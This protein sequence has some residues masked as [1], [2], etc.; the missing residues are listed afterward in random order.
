MLGLIGV[1]EVCA[2]RAVVRLVLARLAGNVGDG[3]GQLGLVFGALEMGYGAAGL[4]V[5]MACKAAPALLVLFGGVLGDRFRRERVMAG[6]EGLAAVAWCGLAVCFFVGAAPFGVVCGL[7]FVA[8]LA[9]SL[10]GPAERGIVADLVQ[11]DARQVVNALVGQSVAVGLLVGLTAAGAVV[12]AAGPG[13]AAGI[14]AVA[15]AVGV[16]LLVRV[17]TRRR[18]GAR[19][20]MLD[21]LR[22]GW[23]EFVAYR[24][25]WLLTVQFTVVAVAAGAFSGVIGPVFVERHGGAGVWGLVAGAEAFGA[26]AGGVAVLWWRPRRAVLV[27]AL[28][29]VALAGPM[30]LVGIHAP[31]PVLAVAMLAPGAAQAVYGVLWTT[32]VQ[33]V[34]APNVLA[35][36]SSWNL[37]GGFALT[38]VAVLGAGRVTAH[39]GAPNAARAAGL[40]VLGTTAV[41][42]LSAR[43]RSFRVA[44][45]A[46]GL[47]RVNA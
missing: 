47:L 5:V 23:R 35:R 45:R 21:E 36:V 19:N 41:V 11:G 34:F 9:R 27:I 3:F 14:K 10:T 26:I 37:L 15:A 33:A 1:R 24:W 22:S 12:A 46:G 29:P 4:A 7:A 43:V 17:R 44:A 32:T 28:L 13:W 38:P 30:L 31:W 40:A 18:G 20:K 42:L 6:A 25:V 16:L 39:V 2:D 8:G